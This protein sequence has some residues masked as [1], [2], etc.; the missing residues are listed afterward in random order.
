MLL[1]VQKNNQKKVKDLKIS[2]N[3][4][5]IA[6][7]QQTEILNVTTTTTPETIFLSQA[8]LSTL[9]KNIFLIFKI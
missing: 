3:V 6:V 9:N 8:M 5:I 2:F 1:D 7:G 4:W